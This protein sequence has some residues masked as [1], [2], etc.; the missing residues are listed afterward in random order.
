M[1]IIDIIIWLIATVLVL[2]LCA[3]AYSVYHSIRMNRRKRKENGIPVGII[4]W[5]VAAF[6]IILSMVIWLTTSFTDMCLVTAAVMLLTA[7]VTIVFD[8][9]KKRRAY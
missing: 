6:V 4:D 8:K 7:T 2:T 1:I 5:S 3:T 9:V